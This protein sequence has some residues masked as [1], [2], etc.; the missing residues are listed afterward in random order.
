MVLHSLYGE[1]SAGFGFQHCEQ[2]N[3][4]DEIGF[5]MVRILQ[6][7]VEMEMQNDIDNFITLPSF[8]WRRGL[9]YCIG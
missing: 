9:W 7:R 1:Y 2:T 4:K 8:D 5:R 3:D 6:G